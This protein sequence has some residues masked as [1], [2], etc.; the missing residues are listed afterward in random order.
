VNRDGKSYLKELIFAV[1]LTVITVKLQRAV[2]S[3]D[4]F[5]TVKMRGALGVKRYAAMQKDAWGKVEGLASDFYE[6]QRL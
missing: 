4:F 5:K 2:A 3:P 1:A 6:I